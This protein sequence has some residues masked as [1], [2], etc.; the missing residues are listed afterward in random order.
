MHNLTKE[1][2][3][4]LCFVHYLAQIL[5]QNRRTRPACGSCRQKMNGRT[6]RCHRRKSLRRKNLYLLLRQKTQRE[7]IFILN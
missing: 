5:Y 7:F 4:L 3:N 1:T 6:P 2:L